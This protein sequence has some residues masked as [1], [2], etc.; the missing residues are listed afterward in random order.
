MVESAHIDR[1]HHDGKSK[2]ALQET[3]ALDEAVMSALLLLQDQ[4]LV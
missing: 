3:V 2:K 4:L 1:A